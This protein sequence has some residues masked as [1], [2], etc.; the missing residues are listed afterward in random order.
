MLA[1]AALFVY[2]HWVEP[3]YLTVSRVDV[4]VAGLPAD[5]EG[6]TIL[7]AS[8]LH[9]A[10]FG[11]GQSRV[12]EVL[13][14][15]AALVAPDRLFDAAVFV[16]DLIDLH[17]QDPAAGVALLE[18]LATRGPTY[19]VPGNHDDLRLEAVLG[20]AG[21]A[22]ARLPGDAA[23]QGSVGFILDAGGRVAFVGADRW[24][25]W[26]QDIAATTQKAAAA[27]EVTVVLL[28][29]PTPALVEAAGR[30]GASLVIA[31]HNHGGQVALP[32]VGAVWAPTAGWFPG[33]V[34]GLFDA[35]GGVPLYV[36]RGLGTSVYRVR[37]FAPP[38]LALLR[39]VPAAAPAPD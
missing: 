3:A 14:A 2:A 13:E 18:I 31:G 37:L 7:V 29:P 5:L 36:S 11:P 22:G 35:E 25:P 17:Y 8:D 38:T 30:A 23:A 16:G 34:A 6:Y 33:R 19:F 9:S 39:L 28:H 1:A 32:F 24:Y 21:A 15:Q 4:P 27:A 12:T 20:A 26:P 10:W